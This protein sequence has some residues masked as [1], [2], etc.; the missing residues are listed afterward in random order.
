MNAPFGQPDPF[1]PATEA[2]NFD[3]PT[4]EMFSLPNLIHRLAMLPRWAG[5]IEKPFPVSEHCRYVAQLVSPKAK[6][7]ALLHDLP[8]AVTADIPAPLKR[9]LELKGAPLLRFEQALF[10]AILKKLALPHPTRAI[11]AEVDRADMTMRAT[12]YRDVVAEKYIGYRVEA[13][14]AR[15]RLRKFPAWYDAAD[16]YRRDL[17]SYL[18]AR[19]IGI[20]C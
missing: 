6:I 19:S 15:F 17:D 3:A 2:M 1:R 18:G 9:W 7:Y 14:P 10:A 16:L 4:P 8:E 20:G 13:P 5:N 11:A 12:E